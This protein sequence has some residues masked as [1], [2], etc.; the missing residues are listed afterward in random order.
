MTTTNGRSSAD[1]RAWERLA[2]DRTWRDWLSIG[3]ALLVGRAA[4]MREAHVNRPQGRGYNT[5]FSTWLERYGFDAI[6]QGDRSR[7]FACMDNRP[8][9]EA[10]RQT[11]P[12]NKRLLLNHPAAVL[13]SWKAKTATPHASKAVSPLTKLKAQNI[14]LLEQVHRLERTGGELFSS[15]D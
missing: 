13:R 5:A 15:K 10:W 8:A 9:I 11:L 6:D 4:A 1:A 14:E 2:S 12:L 3:A 7:L